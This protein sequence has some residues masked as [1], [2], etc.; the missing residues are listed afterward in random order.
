[1]ELSSPAGTSCDHAA[2]SLAEFNGVK[3][4]E[5]AGTSEVAAQ[6]ALHRVAE[7]EEQLA[8]LQAELVWVRQDHATTA[9][10]ATPHTAANKLEK[11]RTLKTPEREDPSSAP[12]SAILYSDLALQRHPSSL[13]QQCHTAISRI[14]HSAENLRVSRS[15][16]AGQGGY[17]VVEGSEEW[18]QRLKQCESARPLLKE[19]GIED[20]ADFGQLDEADFVRLGGHLRKL[21]WRKFLRFSQQYCPAKTQAGGRVPK[22]ASDKL[23]AAFGAPSSARKQINPLFCNS[24]DLDGAAMRALRG[25]R[26]EMEV[27]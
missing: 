11:D 27:A 10:T 12:C 7:L 20:A 15:S 4:L 8:S 13:Y 24:L 3:R 25:S 2:C 14:Q 17:R 9:T 26:C 6:H 18:L 21:G 19:L 5:T 23:C 22:V 16:A 1:M